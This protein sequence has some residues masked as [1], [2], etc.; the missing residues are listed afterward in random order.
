MKYASYAL[1]ASLVTTPVAA[2]KCDVVTQ[3]HPWQVFT[4]TEVADTLTNKYCISFLSLDPRVKGV[5]IQVI[6]NGKSTYDKQGCIDMKGSAKQILTPFVYATG[7][8]AMPLQPLGLDQ[9]KFAYDAMSQG[10]VAGQI[11]GDTIRFEPKTPGF[12]GRIYVT[13]WLNL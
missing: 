11:K 6:N 3:D 10:C 5:D 2:N 13:D 12:Q 4:V 8:P 7:R 1:V 9:A